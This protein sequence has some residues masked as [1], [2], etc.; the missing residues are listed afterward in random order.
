MLAARKFDTYRTTAVQTATPG[1]LL[2]ML[3]DG[4]NR[5]LSTAIDAFK[6]EDPLKFNLVIHQNITKA[7]AIICELQRALRPE[8]AGDLGTNLAQLYDYFNRR[9]QEA[10]VK[11]DKGMI[12]EVRSRMS[13]LRDAW[14][15]SYAKMLQENAPKTDANSTPATF[16]ATR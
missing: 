10:N 16:S 13:D 14:A 5:F 12:E 6:Q 7:Q 9:L 11:K 8:G 4:A 15:Q 2:L 3:Y 1:N